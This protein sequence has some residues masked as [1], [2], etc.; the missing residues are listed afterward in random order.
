MCPFGSARRE[1][2]RGPGTARP[3]DDVR[4]GLIPRQGERTA[5][6]S[7]PARHGTSLA[8]ARGMSSWPNRS[9]VHWRGGM[10]DRAPV[11]GSVVRAIHGPLVAIDAPGLHRP[12][13][14]VDSLMF[15]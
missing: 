1:S 9:M 12:G 5:D 10:G 3:G 14:Y 8:I 7:I 15:S 2:A 6:E 11:V 13:A 4:A